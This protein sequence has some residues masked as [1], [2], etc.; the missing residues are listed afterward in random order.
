MNI[1][2]VF[3]VIFIETERTGSMYTSHKEFYK[4]IVLKSGPTTSLLVNALWNETKTFMTGDVTNEDCY[5][6]LNSLFKGVQ[7]GEEWALKSK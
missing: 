3:A 1:L 6:D 4:S 7:N 2:M 5:K